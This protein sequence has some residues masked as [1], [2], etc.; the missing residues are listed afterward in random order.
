MTRGPSFSIF[1]GMNITSFAEEVG[2]DYESVIEDY[3]GD[4]AALRGDIEAFLPSCHLDELEKAIEAKDED[5]VRKLAHAIR[6]KA[7]KIGLESMAQIARK[8]EESPAER[9][10]AFISPIQREGQLY[11]KALAD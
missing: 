5:R 10:H 1:S 11:A 7:E 2:I 8:L 6:K 9:F 3:C 4:T